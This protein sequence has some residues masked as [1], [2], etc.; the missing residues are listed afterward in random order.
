MS[1]P[2]DPVTFSV[3]YSGT[4]HS[5]SLPPTA[6]LSD[7][8]LLLSS[9]FHVPPNSQTLIH[10][11]RKLPR[12]DP[13]TPL[14]SLLPAGSAKLLLIGP[15]ED[16]VQAT[17]REEDERRRKHEAFEYHR[18]KGTYKVRS[19]VEPGVDDGRWSFGE[20]RPF[21]ED[22]P[23]IGKRRKMLERLAADPAVKDVMVRHKFEVGIL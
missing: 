13:S 23:Q 4:T 22:V 7:L 21:P 16:V 11:G 9:H 20:I 17:A 10:K 6:P 2:P 15:R 5:F 1:S 12:D 18:G 8:H 3:A 14:A 19:T